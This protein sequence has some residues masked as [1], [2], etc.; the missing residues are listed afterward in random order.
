MAG[1]SAVR[2]S[3]EGCLSELVLKGFSPSILPRLTALR[4][5]DAERSGEPSSITCETGWASKPKSRK[6]SMQKN[7]SQKGRGQSVLFLVMPGEFFLAS[8]RFMNIVF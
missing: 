3:S 1:E 8:K 2:L 4:L 6:T 7:N 5:S